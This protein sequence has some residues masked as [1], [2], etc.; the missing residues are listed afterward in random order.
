MLQEELDSVCSNSEGIGGEQEMSSA[1]DNEAAVLS[2]EEET[3]EIRSKVDAGSKTEAG[4]NQDGP[5]VGEN[6]TDDLHEDEMTGV[7]C[8]VNVETPVI[9]RKLEEKQEER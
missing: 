7:E 9:P 8:G 1:G 6:L 4:L 2:E 5:L 3:E